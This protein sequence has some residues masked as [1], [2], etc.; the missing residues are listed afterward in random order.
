MGRYSEV[1]IFRPQMEATRRDLFVST[2]AKIALNLF[3]TGGFV[4]THA[5]RCQAQ[6]ALALES[7]AATVI[8]E[9]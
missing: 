3:E 6:H 7:Q 4:F 1:K 9:C 5:A 8:S 2:H